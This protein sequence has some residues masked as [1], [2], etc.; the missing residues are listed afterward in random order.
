MDAGASREI[1]MKTLVAAVAVLALAVSASA[2]APNVAGTWSVAVEGPH[3]AGTMSL[4]LKQDD[5]KVTGTFV[6]GHRPDIA[7][8]GELAGRTLNLESTRTGDSKGIFK[9]KL[10]DSC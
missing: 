2:A 1:N 7:L 10:K 8:G 3:G 5:K 6:S 4:I 9:A